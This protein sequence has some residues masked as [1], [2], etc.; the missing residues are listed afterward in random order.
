MQFLKML[1]VALTVGL[2]V[3]FAF[4][5]WESVPIRLWGGLIADINLPILL[6][7]TFLA[8]F[9]PMWLAY[10]AVRW[11]SRQR[12]AANERTM[13]DLRASLAAAAPTVPPA[14]VAP[15]PPPLPPEGSLL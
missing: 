3:A 14:E 5:N 10:R 12:Q 1:L 13:A 11:R 7:G 15:P 4:N 2:A 9:V 8:G 6:L